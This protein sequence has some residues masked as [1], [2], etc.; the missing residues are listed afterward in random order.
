[1][2]DNRPF[3]FAAYA[4]TWIAVLSYA[5]RLRRTRAEAE[6]RLAD[7]RRALGVN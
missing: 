5:F 7:A 4:V 2:P 3:I 6:R 1:M